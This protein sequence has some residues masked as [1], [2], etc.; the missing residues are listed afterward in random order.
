M[1]VKKTQPDD[2]IRERLRADYETDVKALIAISQAVAVNV[3]TIAAANGY[4]SA[5]PGAG[6]T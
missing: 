5:R 4:W 2:A 3:A 6:R 1:A